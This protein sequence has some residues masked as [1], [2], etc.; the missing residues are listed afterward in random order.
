VHDL[1]FIG[2]N[3]LEAHL[4]SP[5]LMQDIAFPYLVLLVSGGHTQLL[6]AENIG[7]YRLLA[8]TRD[9]A[10]G[11]CFDKAAKILGLPYPGG[12]N[13]ERAARECADLSAA[14][15]KFPF[16]IPLEHAPEIEFSFSG[17]KT[18]VRNTADRVIKDGK[19]QHEDLAG[20]AASFQSILAK[21]LAL[22]TRK[23]MKKFSEV[24]KSSTPALIVCG[25]V[26]A[27]QTIRAELEQV[28]AAQGFSFLA[29][30]L[31]YCTDNGAMVA[32][33]GLELLKSGKTSPLNIPARP[34]WPLEM[35]KDQ[36]A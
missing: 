14:Q 17:L 2:V 8:T 3:H 19:I 1:P 6:V 26:A 32:W 31:E 34:R 18:S 12:P 36:A 7:E 10:V 9:D 22:Q 16:A 20:I 25:G 15:K 33:A 28:C 5:R 11:E 13:L 35:L 4:L 24:Y 23:A 30:P 21:T 27:N 29:P